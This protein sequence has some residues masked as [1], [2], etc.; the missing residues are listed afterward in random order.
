MARPH[1]LILGTQKAGT[2]SLHNYLGQHPSI[3]MCPVKESNFFA[4]EGRSV[5]DFAG[6]GDQRALSGSKYV[7]T[8]TDWDEYTSLFDQ[9][10]PEATHFGEACPLYLYHPQAAERIKHYLPDV[11]L[12][13]ILRNPVDRAYSGYLMMKRAG[14]E[15][16]PT[17]REAIERE[18]Q[19]KEKPW[20]FSWYYKDVGMYAEQLSR[21]YERFDAEQITIYLFSEFA[22]SPFAVTQD[23][24]T[25]LGL[26]KY[27]FSTSVRRNTSGVD[28]S[29]IISALL[30]DGSWLRKV[31][32]ALIPAS[33]RKTLYHRIEAAN[34]KKPRLSDADRA[35]VD[36]HFEP[37]ISRLES[38][39]ERD[40]SHWRV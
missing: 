37:M 9:A 25:T 4:L 11:H 5:T 32:S 15:P 16:A 22:E 6:P 40:L 33:I 35:Y 10:P 3:F 21:Y 19:R 29:S 8:I 1:F 12:F 24:C 26:T 2:T 31:A 14:R 13:A 20:E 27:S 7:T 17:F 34:R 18:E 23:I 30:A 38:L 36:S 28:R 39:I